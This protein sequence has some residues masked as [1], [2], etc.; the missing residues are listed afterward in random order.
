M[1]VPLALMPL[2]LMCDIYIY[3]FF[4]FM[5]NV[6]EYTGPMDPKSYPYK[7]VNSPL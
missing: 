3:T 4:S 1:N 6:S 7:W 2:G 5:V